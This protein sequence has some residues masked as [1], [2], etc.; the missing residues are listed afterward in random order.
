VNTLSSERIE[1]RVLGA[2]RLVDA[3]TRQPITRP[4]SV[5]ATGVRFVR[6]GRGLYVIAS[7]AGLEAHTR[8]FDSPPA[9]P[10]LRSLAFTLRVAD[11]GGGYL[12]RL[13]ALE[14]PRDPDPAQRNDP[15]SLFRPHDVALLPAPAGE[16]APGWAIIRARVEDGGGA[17]RRGA[18][19][20]VLRAVNGGEE[21]LARGLTEWRGRAAG[22]ALVGVP[23]IP[24]TTFG[25]EAGEDAPV[26][27]TEIDV[28]V[29]AIFDPALDLSAPDAAPDPDALETNRAA[30]STA[31]VAARLASGRTL[32]LR[33]TI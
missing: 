5:S 17:A 21:V 29:E 12:P 4:L 23:G 6:N 19:L 13:A 26:V 14:L 2:V 11:P 20:R 9:Q 30:L 24:V 22:E 27:V 18:L 1:R 3:N 31:R 32:A 33:I 7:A 16:I 15:G 25:E 8:A 10:P 28:E